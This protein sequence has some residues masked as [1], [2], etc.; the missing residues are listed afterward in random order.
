[1]SEPP[2]GSAR[3]ASE[4]LGR[5]AGQP[6]WA[7]LLDTLPAVFYL[8]RPDGTGLWVSDRVT[9]LLEITPA[10]WLAGY[11]AWLDRV[12]PED[13][14]RVMEAA[15]D[16]GETGHPS[17]DE[18][19][20]VLADGTV[21]WIHDRALLR[22]DG[23]TGELLIHGVMLDVSEQHEL[24]EASERHGRLY[25]ALVEHAREA[26]TIV[27][28]E[29]DVRYINP[30]MGRVVGRPPEW[31]RG[32]SPL[33]LMPPDDRARAIAVLEG[34]RGRPGA[35]LPGEFRL[36]HRDGSWRTVEGIATNLLHDP[37]VRGIVLNY[38]D[39]TTEREHERA[40]RELERRRRSLLEEMVNAESEQRSR[41]A[42]ELHDDALQVLIACL[43]E[44]DRS[45]RHLQHGDVVA[46]IH[47]ITTAR[48]TLHG[49]TDRT[50]QITFELRPQLLEAA[51]LGAAVRELAD[52]LHRESGVRVSVRTRLGRYPVD[53]E[54]LAYRT[55]REALE[56]VR[57]H[58]R[59]T[60]VSVRVMERRG[61]I[62]V[63]VRDDGRGFADDAPRA[64]G[65]RRH[66][67]ET[68]SERVRA[69]GGSFRLTSEPGEGTTVEFRLPLPVPTT[70]E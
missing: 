43:V 23:E 69:A 17:S 3:D 34:L 48:S 50:R 32:R 56:N 31:F 51:G 62:H 47:S 42:D 24:R 57:K 70:A 55:I 66:G 58:A 2:Q 52:E 11:D 44:L 22:R 53:I 4:A 7:E 19:R 59:A 45:E 15:R 49:A 40:M 63:R 67:I 54:T 36:R 29:G 5:L 37:A 33:E 61:S 26:V 16:F 68:A 46:A 38:R 21:R 10:Q 18:Y 28:P 14:S 60:T 65:S 6:A 25:E 64:R 8:D 41:I 30:S 27:G 1:M 20:I 39:V 9:Q 35:Q 12:H 13:R